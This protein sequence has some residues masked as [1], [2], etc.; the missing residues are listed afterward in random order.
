MTYY[1]LNLT[2][3]GNMF[4]PFFLPFWLVFVFLYLLLT[5]NII[6]GFSD[7]PENTYSLSKVTL[8]VFI[9]SF[10]LFVNEYILTHIYA[11]LKHFNAPQYGRG[12]DIYDNL[13]YFIF[14]LLTVCLCA[15]FSY[16]LHLRF[17]AK[18]LTSTNASK[19]NTILLISVLTSPIIFLISPKNFLNFLED[20]LF[21]LFPLSW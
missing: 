18:Y 11:T 16:R 17:T 6:L 9:I 2:G 4:N 5:V 8:C 10:C 7:F 3:W 13:G 21:F 12:L 14:T 19:H 20:L 15:Y 1:W